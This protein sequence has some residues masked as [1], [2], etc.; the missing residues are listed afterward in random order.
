MPRGVNQLSSPYPLQCELDLEPTGYV[1]G[2]AR[3]SFFQMCGIDAVRPQ[4]LSG[5]TRAV[6]VNNSLAALPSAIDG[7]ILKDRHFIIPIP[8]SIAPYATPFYFAA[9]L[10]FGFA[11]IES[12]GLAPVIRPFSALTT[13]DS[14]AS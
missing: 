5:R 6:R 10:S 2:L 12:F 4:L 3:L 11:V 14:E 7:Y 9:S 13:N 8:K 1:A